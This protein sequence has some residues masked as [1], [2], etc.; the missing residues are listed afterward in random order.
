MCQHT[1]Y[2]PQN[3]LHE[4]LYHQAHPDLKPPLHHRAAAFARALQLAPQLL[5]LDV[6]RHLVSTEEDEVKGIRFLLHVYAAA[7]KGAR[8]DGSVMHAVC[9][10]D[11]RRAK[12]LDT[13]SRERRQITDHVEVAVPDR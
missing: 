8:V 2:P 6:L 4:L 1:K 13:A 10:P 7:S 9:V 11:Q 5:Q 3:S 12:R